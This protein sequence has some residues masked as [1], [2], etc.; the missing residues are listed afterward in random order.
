MEEDERRK[1]YGR[2]KKRW[3]KWKGWKLVDFE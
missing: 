1:G 3:I 2:E